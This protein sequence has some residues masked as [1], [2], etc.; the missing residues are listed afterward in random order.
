MADVTPIPP[1]ESAP[2]PPSLVGNALWSTLVTVWGTAVS[3]ALTPFLVARLGEQTYGLYLLLLSVSGLMGILNLGLGEATL[4]YVAFYYGRQ[5]LDGINRVLGATLAVYGITGL[6]G[7]ALLAG[8]APWIVRWL[9]IPVAEQ[10]QACSLLRLVAISL[11]LSFPLGALGAIPQTVQRYDLSSQ[12]TILQSVLQT[13]GSVLIVLGSGGLYG[14]L[15]WNIV[16]ALEQLALNGWIAHRL[17]PGVRLWPL[18]TRAG[19]R[20][21]FSYG[22]FS[23]ATQILGLIWEQA[24]KLLLGSFISTASVA[25]LTVPKSLAFRLSYALNAT[26]GPLL[27]RFSAL[28]TRAEQQRLYRLATWCTSCAGVVLFVPLTVLMPDFLRLWINP[29]FAAQSAWIG[30]VLAFSCLLRGVY[31]PFQPLF[32]GLG[33]PQYVTLVYLGSGLTS[34]LLNVLLIS[35]FGLAGAGYTY[36]ITTAWGFAALLFAWRQLL[37]DRAWQPLVRASGLPLLSGL[38]WLGLGLVARSQATAPGWIGLLIWAALLAGSAALWL[39]ALEWI[40]GR[41][42]SYSAAVWQAGRTYVTT[43]L[44]RS[45]ARL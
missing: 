10:A 44:R 27:P 11:G 17:I 15:V 24:D 12:L 39:V 45:E 41:R 22:F 16:L 31:I 6:V 25:Y 30:Q 26:S 23:L 8:G 20:E 4:R 29:T 5:D 13:V 37:Q 32:R 21:V 36:V 43:R 18:P 34:L 1:A 33:K 42:E 7:W 2:R 38:G 3:L 40:L 9:A 19:L 35:K 28:Q 14:L